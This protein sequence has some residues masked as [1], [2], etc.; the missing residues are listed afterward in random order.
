MKRCNSA[1]NDEEIKPYYPVNNQISITRPIMAV[2]HFYLY[3]IH[4]FVSYHPF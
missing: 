1:Q 3:I 4:S 2:P